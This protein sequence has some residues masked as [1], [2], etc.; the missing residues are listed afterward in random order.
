MNVKFDTVNDI[1]QAS[2]T[3]PWTNAEPTFKQNDNYIT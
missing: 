3:K 2:V 1:L